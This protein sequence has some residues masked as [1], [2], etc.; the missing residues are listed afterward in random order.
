[1]MANN[2]CAADDVLVSVRNVSYRCCDRDVLSDISFEIKKK[3]I[4]SIIGPNGAGKTTMIKILLGLLEPTSGNVVRSRDLRVGYA[5]QS[6]SL[7]EYLPI[8][9]RCLLKSTLS[10]RINMD[11]V[12]SITGIECLLDC[13]TSQLSGGELKLVMLA[14]ALMAGYDMIVLD[15]IASNFDIEKRD[16]FYQ[17]LH[18]I[19]EKFGM[20]NCFGVP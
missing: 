20:C 16:R 17:M 7:S 13:Q 2:S 5:P 10:P 6:F 14:K 4:I 3:E 11:Y 1:M 9:A 8:T 12:V 19:N 18:E 15:E